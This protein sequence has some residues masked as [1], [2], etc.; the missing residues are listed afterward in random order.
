ML[1]IIRSIDYDTLITHIYLAKRYFITN[2]FDFI[3][4]ISLQRNFLT[5]NKSLTIK[6]IHRLQ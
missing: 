5:T 3:F 6:L 2:I 4:E 1:Q